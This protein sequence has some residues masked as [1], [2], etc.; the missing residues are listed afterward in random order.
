MNCH[1]DRS[2]ANWRDLLFHSATNQSSLR[3]PP[4]P[5]SSRPK[6]RDL[7]FNGLLLE[8]FFSSAQ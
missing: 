6:W 8:M 2:E 3:A 5:L 1:P 7:Q 4:S